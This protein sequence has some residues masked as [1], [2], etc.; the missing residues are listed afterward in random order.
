MKFLLITL[1]F[2]LPA[3]ANT[4]KLMRCLGEEEKQ[5]H[6]KKEISGRYKL[7]QDLISALVQLT[8][9]VSIKPKYYAQACRK[10]VKNTSFELLKV[11]LTHKQES[12]MVIGKKKSTM[13]LIAEK[14]ITELYN[15]ITEVFIDYLSG[16]RARAPTSD[17]IVE[18][19]PQL[20]KFY[21]SLLYLQEDIDREKILGEIKDINGLFIKLEYVDSMYKKCADQKKS[22]KQ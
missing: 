22:K 11:I 19:I 6:L 1:F 15:R 3:F 18:H 9:E 17:C 10:E 12:F 4:A 21:E 8:D 13:V 20:K 16:I 2:I 5:L 7:N 14:S